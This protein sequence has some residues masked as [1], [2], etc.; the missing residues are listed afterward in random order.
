[1][2][3]RFPVTKAEPSKLREIARLGSTTVV[4]VETA[5]ACLRGAADEITKLRAELAAARQKAG[6]QA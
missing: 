6:D 2:S 3:S 5:Q 1:M 4:W